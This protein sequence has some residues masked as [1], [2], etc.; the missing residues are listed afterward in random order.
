MATFFQNYFFQITLLII[1]G[2]IIIFLFAFLFR[3]TSKGEG[4]FLFLKTSKEFEEE[5]KNLMAKEMQKIIDELNQDVQSFATATFEAYKREVS[6][7]PQRIDQALTQFFQFNQVLQERLSKEVEKKIG[8][9]EKNFLETQRILL[10]EARKRTDQLSAKLG[11][12]IKGLYSSALRPVIK[13]V[14]EVEREIENYKK[15]KMKEVEE[16][17]YQIIRDVAKK[18]IGKTIDLSTHEKLVIEALEKARK[19]KIL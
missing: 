16:K 2:L 10:E 15:E 4:N 12:D 6:S 5:L 9:F 19:E 11:E 18:I 17:I 14:E 13:K 7:M 1:L 3:R 8:E